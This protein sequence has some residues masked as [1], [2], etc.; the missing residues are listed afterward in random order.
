MRLKIQ[1]L[2]GFINYLVGIRRTEIRVLLVNKT[3]PIETLVWGLGI[4]EG[5]CKELNCLN[6][7]WENEAQVEIIRK[8]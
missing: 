1:L 5:F 2:I 3:S 7:E 8:A 6:R 4:Y